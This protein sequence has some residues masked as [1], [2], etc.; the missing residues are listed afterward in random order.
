MPFYKSICHLRE[1]TSVEWYKS[2]NANNYGFSL[3]AFHSAQTKRG[4]ILFFWPSR[5][6]IFIGIGYG[7]AKKNL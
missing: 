1:N 4:K 2:F 3:N 7:L 5:I 6:S